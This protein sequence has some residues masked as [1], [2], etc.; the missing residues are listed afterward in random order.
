M[1]QVPNYTQ[2]VSI[3]LSEVLADIGVDERMILKTR[4]TWLLKESLHNINYQLLD[5]DS[6]L[7][8]IF[9]SQSEGT[10]TLEMESDIDQLVNIKTFTV[11]QDWND[12]T[13][14]VH[15]LLMIEDNSVSPGYCLLQCPVNDVPLS[16]DGD[17]DQFFFQDRTGKLFVKNSLVYMFYNDSEIHGPAGTYQG[18]PGYKDLDKVFA[19]HCTKW[20]QQARQWLDQ[21]D[22]GQWPS[23]EMKQYCSRTGCF[24]VCV[25][26]RGSKHE[27][28]EWRI[29]TSLAE[30]CLM[31]DLDITQ[32][33]CYVLMKM[34]LKTYIT[35]FLKDVISSYMCKTVVSHCIANTH[36]NIWRKDNLLFCL[37]QCL[38][39]LY[40]NIINENCPHFIIP[41]NNLMRGKISPAVKPYILEILNNIINSEGVAL[42]RI[43]CDALGSRLHLKFYNLCAFKESDI[44]SATLLLNFALTKSEILAETDDFLK[45][46]SPNEAVEKLKNYISKALYCQYEGLDKTASLLLLPWYCTTLGSV[47]ASRNICQY[48]TVSADALKLISLG[49]NTDVASSKLKL[50]SIFYCVQE[51]EKADLVLGEIESR[52]DLQIVAS[53][54]GCHHQFRRK[55]VKQRFGQL[56]NNYSEEVLQYITASCV[57]FLPCEIHCVP[58][59][60]RYEFFRSTQEDRLFRTKEDNKWMDYAVVDS[61]PYLYFLQYKVYSHLG[62]YDQKQATLLKLISTIK[63]EPNLGHRETA[64]N[65]LGKCMEQEGRAGDAL[66]CYSM[67]LNVRRRNNAAKIHICILLSVLI[68]ART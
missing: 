3:R 46:S 19:L 45:D 34:I 43:K 55:I 64:L 27:Q 38:Y 17:S 53:V 1:Y 5:K 40:T 52:Y 56:C 59:E 63:E 61:L 54:C 33:R 25:G 7:K 49:L 62:R 2:T 36:S 35:P 66:Y 20:P 42:L 39:L 47:L 13:P 23:A 4:R 6:T 28:I 14:G 30:R 24:V 31:F 21:E 58:T 10:T 48:N 22:E 44:I 9:G 41:G 8:Y 29:S 67:S 51:I 15:N 50:A 18:Q 26:C 37:T 32:I 60:L 16:A 12:W 11:I 65:I 57:R 68:N